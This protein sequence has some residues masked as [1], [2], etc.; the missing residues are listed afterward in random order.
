M[1]SEVPKTQHLEDLA[2]WLQEIIDEEGFDT[3]VRE[4]LY[5]VMDRLRELNETHK[6]DILRDIRDLGWVVLSHADLVD[7]ANYCPGESAPVKWLFHKRGDTF[8]KIDGIV[9]E[10]RSRTDEEALWIAAG[11]IARHELSSEKAVK[12]AD[13]LLAKGKSF[14]KAIEAAKEKFKEEE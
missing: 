8:K 5:G 14:K 6:P 2:E 10:G 12:Y 3:F 1:S 4:G 7:A 11:R 13:K 9:V